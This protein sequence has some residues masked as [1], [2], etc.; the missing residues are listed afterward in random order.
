MEEIKEKKH[1]WKFFAGIAIGMVLMVAG[2]FLYKGYYTMNLPIVGMVTVKLPTY[3]LFH[4]D[5]PEKIDQKELI[6]KVDE[7][8]HYLDSEYIYERDSKKLLDAACEGI[9]NGLKGEDP[10][11]DYYSA[12]EYKSSLESWQGKYKGIGVY[13]TKDEVTGGMQVVRPIPGGP[14]EEAGIRNG[15]IIIKADDFDIRGLSLDDAAD[16]H[17]KGEVGTSVKL[18]ILRGTEE[19]E[20]MVERRELDSETVF[21]SVIEYDGRTYGYVYI[22]QFEGST[23]DNFIKTVDSFTGK[24]VDG[25][26]IDLRDNPGGDMNVCLNMADYLLPDDIGTY[27]G[28]EASTLKTGR[29]LLLTIR[30]KTSGDSCYYGIDGHSNDI[31]V[32]VLVN[33]NS[34]SASE[35]F[36]GVMMSYGYPSLGKITYG[37]GIV[38]TVRMLY[39][40]SGIK[41]T[42]GEY[43]L[44]DSSRI[45]GKGITP[46][47]IVEES[48]E[49][50][51]KGAD[52]E[53]PDPEIDNQLCEALKILGEKK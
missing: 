38:Q 5:D 27:T 20:M 11:A 18:T 53:N 49:F 26:V 19:I 45:H 24:S 12:E 8:E 4:N 39:D 52:A 41:Y 31:P 15:D 13:I 42:S 30:T 35:I 47:F 50:L 51:E 17:I 1:N 46:E 34:A 2:W 44:P 37:K 43:I 40:M 9:F 22:S 21:P 32:I 10:Y 25:M 7:I 14:A 29:T 36:T 48:E 28:S 23:Y 16:N 6:R 33:E 3:S